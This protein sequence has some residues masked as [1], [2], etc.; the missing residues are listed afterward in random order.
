MTGGLPSFAGMRPAALDDV[1]FVMATERLEANALRISRWEAERHRASLADPDFA[2][3]I[4]FDAESRPIAFAI[5]R[6]LSDR[7]GNVCLQRLAVARPGRGIGSAFLRT[8][9][10]EMFGATPCHRFWLDVFADNA[11]ARGLYGSLGLVEEGVLRE[12]IVRADGQR[13]D[14]V[15]MS[16]LRTE[17]LSGQR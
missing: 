7:H 6:G 4:S 5:L 13:A 8:V 2:Y 17:W 14:Q 3:R 11:V 15:V 1:P 12:V 10:D 9:I 16:L